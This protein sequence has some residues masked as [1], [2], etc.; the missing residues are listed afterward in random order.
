[1]GR[2]LGGVGRAGGSYFRY[3]DCLSTVV[4]PWNRVLVDRLAPIGTNSSRVFTKAFGARPSFTTACYAK[5]VAPD[6]PPQ[7]AITDFETTAFATSAGTITEP[8]IVPSAAN[9]SIQPRALSAFASYPERTSA[10][11]ASVR[12]KSS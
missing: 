9:P 2:A 5:L 6:T 4:G 3:G 10:H 7:A 12:L 11:A 1:M 8:A